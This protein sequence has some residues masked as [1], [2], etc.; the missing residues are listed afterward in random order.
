MVVL[1]GGNAAVDA[2]QTA[3]RLGAGSVRIVSLEAREELPAFE[4]EVLQAVSEGVVLDCSWGPVRITGQ[5]GKASGIEL[6]R[7]VAVFDDQ[8]CFSP[9]FDDTVRRA[10][11]CDHVITAIGQAGDTLN[12]A[13]RDLKAADPLTLQTAREKVF[14]AGDCVS[15][16]S[17]VV[18]AMASGRRAA[19]SVDRLLNGDSLTY[20]RDY[21]GPVVT[22]FEIDTS[23]AVDRA[24]VCPSVHRFEGGGDFNEL[25]ETLTPEKARS[26]AERCYSCGTP[27]GRYRTCWFCLPCEV[28]C[29][30]EALWVEIPYLLR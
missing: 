23:G 15:G 26:E 20:N 13:A 18:R 21:A 12:N 19:E 2:A 3:L 1:G 27:F 22:D 29:P 10:L 11:P 6:T 30:V 8:G 9:C 4:H 17:S 25:E 5:G 28:S 24:R 16:P 14:L 7:C